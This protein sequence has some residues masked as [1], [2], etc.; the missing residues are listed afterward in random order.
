MQYDEGA[1]PA[2]GGFLGI[3]S[4]W[5]YSRQL[6]AALLAEFIGMMIFQIYGGNAPDSVAA[7]G[8]GITLVVLGEIYGPIMEPRFAPAPIEAL[9]HSSNN[10]M[11][12]QKL[13]SH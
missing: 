3:V 8:N 10:I 5:N 2:D 7:F 6:K 11:Q 13:P 1:E 12:L 9:P 4:F